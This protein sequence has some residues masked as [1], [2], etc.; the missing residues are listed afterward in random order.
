MVNGQATFSAAGGNVLNIREGMHGHLEI[1]FVKD[2]QVASAGST[3]IN[4]A[5][6]V[7]FIDVATGEA[8]SWANVN[9]LFSDEGGFLD[10]A[11]SG[12]QG[13]QSWGAGTED[14]IGT[15]QNVFTGGAGLMFGTADSMK[16]GDKALLSVD[17]QIGSTATNFQ[18]T[19]SVGG[20]AVKIDERF[21]NDVDDDSI[22][23]YRGSFL[24][25]TGENGLQNIN[26]TDGS[27]QV[28]YNVAQLD[29]ATG[30]VT[31]GNIQLDMNANQNG[32]QVDEVVNAE[33]RGTDGLASS[34]TKLKDINSFMTPDGTNV[35]DTAQTVTLYGN[36]QSVDV[37]LEGND[38]LA[39]LEE[40]LTKA[41]TDGLGISMGDVSTDNR[42]VDFVGKGSATDNTDAAVEGTM[43]IRSLFNGSQGDI[44]IVAE[45]QVID[46][47]NFTE[48]Q[49][50]EENIY[51]VRVTDAHT[52]RPVGSDIVGDGVLKGVIQ[53]V[54]VQLKG[55]IGITADFD[56]A[57]QRFN[58]EAESDP[59]SM[60]LHLVDSGISFQI[61]ANA[62]QTIDAN[63]AQ[64]DTKSMGLTNTLVVSQD[65]AQQAITDI[66]KAI[67]MVST[68]RAKMGAISNRLDHTINSLSVSFENLQAAESRIRDVNVAKEMSQFT[69]NQMLTQSAQS[70][71]G[72]ANALPQGV[73]Q[74]LF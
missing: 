42:V 31:I 40:K 8:G 43:L 38:S 13:R 39:R 12:V 1:E 11:G 54:D 23:D 68:E 24:V 44:S 71:L 16:A 60:N 30:S 53:G 41:V 63:I 29:S 47:L 51:N 65:L 22:V 27:K 36:G 25:F 2:F 73:M 32:T 28:T 49:A 19:L 69:L 21:R 17:G 15:T 50:S 45:Q 62:G 56:E 66:D 48:I 55:N 34:Y 7:R 37:Y 35:F 67:N 46:A 20:G 72:Q 10:L 33:I 4:D 9:M 3:A 57:R 6:R 14:N 61:G 26:L 59:T 70:M 5:A 52:G 64:M 74:L 18:G 58:F